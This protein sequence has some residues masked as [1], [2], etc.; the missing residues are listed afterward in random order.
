VRFLVFLVRCAC[1]AG[2]VLFSPFA[3]STTASFYSADPVYTRA[4]FFPR[5][6]RISSALLSFP[7][8]PTS[9]MLFANLCLMD[10][11]LLTSLGLSL[12]CCLIPPSVITTRTPFF[13]VTFFSFVF[14]NCF[15]H[16][17]CTRFCDSCFHGHRNPSFDF[18]LICQASLFS[19]PV[20][21]RP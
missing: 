2:C 4:L 11:L 1:W 18:S 8:R 13:F 3:L 14:A 17:P 15:L 19:P 10:A 9:D 7:V 21:Y 5:F 16:L 12:W 6:S 20:H